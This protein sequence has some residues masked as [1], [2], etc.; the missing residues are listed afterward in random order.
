MYQSRGSNLA[1]RAASSFESLH[2]PLRHFSIA[3]IAAKM[4]TI[5][6][7]ATNQCFALIMV[8]LVRVL[9]RRGGKG[10]V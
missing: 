7:I 8:G 9:P 2:P 4:H 3:M 10:K 1:L 5:H 6:I